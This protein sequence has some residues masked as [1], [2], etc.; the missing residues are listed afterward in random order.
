MTT[1][2]SDVK[3][4]CSIPYC[5]KVISYDDRYSHV[6]ACDFNLIVCTGCKK[7]VSLNCHDDHKLIV[8]K[9][10]ELDLKQP[11]LRGGRRKMRL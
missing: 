1:P 6:A 8:Q 9:Q 7:K 5:D 4:T 3:L 2:L 10:I 11:S